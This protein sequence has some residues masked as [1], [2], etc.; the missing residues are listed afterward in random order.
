MKCEEC[1]CYKDHDCMAWD[2]DIFVNPNDDCV[3]EKKIAVRDEYNAS[4]RG[5]VKYLCHDDPDDVREC[6]YGNAREVDCTHLE[7]GK[8]PQDCEYAKR[9]DVEE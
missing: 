7:A 1:K 3:L 9:K 2:A 8:H 4:D 5:N 6:L